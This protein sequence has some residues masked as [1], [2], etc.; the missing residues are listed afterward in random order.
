M[1][2]FADKLDDLLVRNI[3]YFNYKSYVKRLALKGNEKVLEIGCGGGNL[4]RFL[5][6]RLPF[7]KLVCIDNSKYW[8]D[9]AKKRLRNIRKNYLNLQGYMLSPS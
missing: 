8:I 9:K 2:S 5:A 4:S 1:P 3:A 6:K 7:G